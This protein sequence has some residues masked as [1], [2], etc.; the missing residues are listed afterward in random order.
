MKQ[1]TRHKV[2][3]KSRAVISS[4]SATS[5]SPPVYSRLAI[6]AVSD[7][8]RRKRWTSMFRLNDLTLGIKFGKL[9]GLA[10]SPRVWPA[11]RPPT[12]CRYAMERY[13]EVM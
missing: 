8:P 2:S 6:A 7:P 4:C 3:F 10:I 11:G 12:A 5:G 1:K 13:T 9:A